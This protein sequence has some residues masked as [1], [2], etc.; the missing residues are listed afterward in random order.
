MAVIHRGEL[1]FAGTPAELRAAP[2]LRHP[3]AG[4]SA[5]IDERQPLAALIDED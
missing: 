5:C 4:V 1:R 3:G 2:R